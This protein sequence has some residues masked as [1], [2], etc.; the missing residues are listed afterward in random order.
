MSNYI[1]LNNNDSHLSLG[2]MFNIIKKLSINKTSAIQTEIFC[3]LFSIDN[4]SE[5]TVGNYCTGYRAIGSNYKQIYLNYKKKYQ[6]NKNILIPTINNLISIIDG[7]IYD[8]TT[9]NEINDSKS[10][11][12]LCKEDVYNVGEEVFYDT[13]KHFSQ[14]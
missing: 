12:N 14:K 4:I 9:I 1:K 5:T 6:T 2:N 10:L 7:Y 11:K 8:M 3:I 13:F